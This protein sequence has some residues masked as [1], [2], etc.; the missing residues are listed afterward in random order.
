MTDYN[1]ESVVRAINDTY[2]DSANAYDAINNAGLTPEEFYQASS[3]NVIDTGIKYSVNGDGDVNGIFNN[4]STNLSNGNVA[5]SAINSNMQTGTASESVNVQY[6]A[7]SSVNQSGKVELS[8]GVTKYKTGQLAPTTGFKAVVGSVASGVAAYAVGISAGKKLSSF[9]YDQNPAFFDSIGLSTLDPATWKTIT[10]DMSDTGVEGALKT[11]FNFLLGLN[12]DGSTQAYLSA[13]AYKYLL[14]GLAQSGMFDSAGEY[15]CPKPT[16]NYGWY[17]T[18]DGIALPQQVELTNITSTSGLSKIVYTMLDPNGFLCPIQCV[19]NGTKY[20][21]IYGICSATA[22]PNNK[23]RLDVYKADGTLK[24][25][26]SYIMDQSCYQIRLADGSYYYPPSDL[27]TGNALS[28]RGDL[29][30]YNETTLSASDL[31]L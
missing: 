2:P 11:A 18:S 19:Y 21:R 7:E 8:A 28:D 23:V 4:Y 9:V 20:Q 27:R 22:S 15:I 6:A 29:S 1:Y 3:N 14:Y 30:I 17:F 10:S 26:Y 13:D 31:K 16:G 24:E 25:S 5:Q 12:E